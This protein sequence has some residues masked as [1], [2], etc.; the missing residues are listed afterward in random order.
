MLASTGV[1][2]YSLVGALLERVEAEARVHDAT[3]VRRIRLAVGRLAGVE[4]ELLRWAFE[5][6]REGTV[7]ANA[8]LEIA[9]VEVR[10]E[11]P[12]SGR[13]LDATSELK[14]PDCG[15]SGRLVSGDELTL[16][17]LELEVAD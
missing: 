12:E 6:L 1:H 2:E 10:W 15:A 16:E 8:E 9:D 4:A 5:Q 14:C 7:C 13:V 3:A 11:C 17:T